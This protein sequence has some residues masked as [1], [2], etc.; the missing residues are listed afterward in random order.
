MRNKWYCNIV[1]INLFSL[2]FSA[3]NMYAFKTYKDWPK[4]IAWWKFDTASG[5]HVIE[6]I[7]LRSDSVRGNFKFVKGVSGKALKL[8]GFTTQIRSKPL[9]AEILQDA[10]TV[11]AWVALATYPWNWCPVVSQSDK[12]N[13]GFYFGVGPRGEVGLFASVNGT[14]EKCIS[15]EKIALRKKKHREDNIEEHIER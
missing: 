12:E 4:P 2:L 11:E 15:S 14:W 1:L 9:P 7:S 6:S 3:S 5:S 13:A 10:F 8:D